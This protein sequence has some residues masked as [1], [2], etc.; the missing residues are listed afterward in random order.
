MAGRSA[1]LTQ[2]GTQTLISWIT[3]K[4]STERFES[5]LAGYMADAQTPQALA[6]EGVPLYWTGT[7]ATA[8]ELH[9]EASAKAAA[10][11]LTHG[12][13]PHGESLRTKVHAAKNRTTGADQDRRDTMGWVLAAPKTVSL[14]LMHEDPAV[15][16]AV[17]QA[18]D[19][20]SEEAVR[21]LEHQV[22]VRRRT[23]GTRSEGVQGLVGV[24]TAHYTSSAGDPHLHVH[25]ILNASAPAQSDGK[26]RAL[27]SRVLFASQR[28]AE[29]AFEATLRHELSHRLG[30]AL[31]TWTP[32]TVGSAVT[33]ELPDLMPAV[34]RYSQ[35]TAHM[36]DIA[37]RMGLALERETYAVHGLIWAKHRADKHA[38][39]EPLEHALDAAL[40]AGGDA[41]TAIYHE[42][43][44]RLGPA[45]QE[46]LRRLHVVQ[47][48]VAPNPSHTNGFQRLQD[49]LGPG[50]RFTQREQARQNAHHHAAQ[51][52]SARDNFRHD[53]FL[54][55]GGGQR[56]PEAVLHRLETDMQAARQTRFA[57]VF[58][59]ED[60]TTVRRLQQQLAD[61]QQFNALWDA[62]DIAQ[63][64]AQ[65]IQEQTTQ[66]DAKDHQI[67]Q[68]IRT[69]AVTLGQR[70]GPFIAADVVAWWR[71]Q[72]WTLE[73]SRAL[74]ADTLAFW[75]HKGLIHVSDT[76]SPAQLFDT[77]R[78]G[79]S[80]DTTVNQRVWGHTGKL[81]SEDL[82]Q[83]EIALS[84]HAGQLAQTP[85]KTLLVD[86]EGLTPDQARAVTTIADGRALTTIQGVA[87][88]G[89]SYLL[90]PVVHQAQR[91]GLQ[92]LV[93]GRNAK[94]AHALGQELGIPSS[95]IARWTHRKQPSTTPTLLLVDEAGLVDQKDWVTILDAA[96]N[97]A[98]QIV[99]V[100]DRYQAQPIDRLASWAV[101]TDAVQAH[102]GYAELTQTFRNQAW[103]Q[104][105]TALR[106]GHEEALDLAMAA[107]RLIVAA[108]RSTIE[109]LMASESAPGWLGAD[110]TAAT[111]LQ[112]IQRGEDALAVAAT[113]EEAAAIAEAVQLRKE[114]TV[115]SRT[116]LRWSQQTGVGDRVRTRQNDASRRIRNGD[117]WA[118]TRVTA[119]G[120][121]LRGQDGRQ[122]HVPHAWATQ[123]LEL[124]Y[125][126]TMDSSQGVTVDRV[127]VCVGP[128]L[129]RT[130]LY[131]AATRG[132]QA[133]AY[134]AEAATRSAAAQIVRTAIHRDDL[135]H[136]M[137]EHLHRHT[138]EIQ[139]PP[140]VIP[141]PEISADWER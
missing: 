46:A 3:R 118:V 92:V 27:D 23:G 77:V 137:Q 21:T 51:T 62:H 43:Q 33:W 56:I 42:W 133:P 131:S 11:V 111:V 67:V 30:L 95:T 132:R 117:V 45:E 41:A 115:D 101:I 82:L 4:D 127:V 49:L 136:T 75:H 121:H 78:Y 108:P 64:R 73:E 9:G 129:G 50:H 130:G 12:T 19:R 72:G 65:T 68:E 119:Q 44:S 105:A 18:L 134:V 79:R 93:L 98:I 94:L 37:G 74:A 87:G 36:Q 116:H 103:D 113:N 128:L 86:I 85:R 84:Q 60:K 69:L 57:W 99:A 16:T 107:H 13:G 52:K 14:L 38:V 114:I 100:G 20:A 48:T 28:I 29:A 71:G 55:G 2:S 47:D 7:M 91:Q 76:L 126:A 81:I 122:T 139:S 125:A 17:H 54:W 39:A 1:L 15:R 135:A 26:W 63:H 124:A 35:A 112:L 34:E 106:E 88:A 10:R 53:H 70:L 110:R 24:K 97:P 6:R 96:D 90:K 31:N 22:T 123:H 66:A 32:H 120:I 104:E 40:A 138:R 8:L 102:G 25:Y 59:H 58:H 5:T 83:R 109:R 140:R 61:A 141:P 89:K 80:T